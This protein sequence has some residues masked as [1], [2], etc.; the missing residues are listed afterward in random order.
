ML[1]KFFLCLGQARH[2]AL[3]CHSLVVADKQLGFLISY[4]LCVLFHSNSELTSQT[5]SPLRHC[6]T[7]WIGDRPIAGPL[8]TQD[9]MN[10]KCH[11]HASSAIRT[12]DTRIPGNQDLKRS[13][14]MLKE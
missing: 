9:N 4:G 14:D 5:L 10:I 12:H 3:A 11:E 8:C 6:N 1:H 2:E 7:T 13:L